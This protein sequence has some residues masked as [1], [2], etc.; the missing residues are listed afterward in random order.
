[1]RKNPPARL[2]HIITMFG[3]AAAFSRAIGVHKAA[4]LRWQKGER[5]ILPHHQFQILRAAKLAGFDLKEVAF[6]LEI[7]RC[8]CCGVVVDDDLRDI[9]EGI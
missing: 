5:E 8:P 4:V 7:K 3:S 1:M 6:S 9:L 2:Q